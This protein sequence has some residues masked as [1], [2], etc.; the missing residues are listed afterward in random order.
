MVGDEFAALFGEPYKS[1][2]KDAGALVVFTL[3]Q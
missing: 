2:P 3:K 1:M